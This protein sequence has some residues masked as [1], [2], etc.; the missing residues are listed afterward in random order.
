MFAVYSAL[1]TRCVP[2]RNDHLI[3]NEIGYIFA[4]N[5][6]LGPPSVLLLQMNTTLGFVGAQVDITLL[7]VTATYIMMK[8]SRS[9]LNGF[10]ATVCYSAFSLYAGWCAVATIL[11]V[12][13]LLASSGFREDQRDISETNQ[14]LVMYWV[15]EVVYFIA[16]LRE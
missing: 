12:A 7:L 9:H 10:E 5:L 11:N 6:A 4:L 2:R 1:P 16:S 13:F 14:A 8:I 3:Y 15:A